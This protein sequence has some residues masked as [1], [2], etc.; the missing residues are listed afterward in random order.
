MSSEEKLLQVL[1]KIEKHL[2]EVNQP[3]MCFT[4]EQAATRLGIS[5]S[6]IKELRTRGD[7]K[8]IMIDGSVRVPL[9][10]IQEYIKQRLGEAS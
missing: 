9:S 10:S 7:L 1:E 6:K 8:V 3:A 4:L 2:E 5:L